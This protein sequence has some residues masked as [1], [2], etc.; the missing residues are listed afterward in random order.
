MLKENCYITHL[1]L[2]NNGIGATGAVMLLDILAS[3]TT[4][5]YLNL[6]GKGRENCDLCM[7]KKNNLYLLLLYF[8]Y[9]KV[10]HLMIK[11][12]NLFLKLLK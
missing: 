2:S 8:Y 4:V 6:S 9:F 1:D 5:T 11:L 7:Y 10:V 3:N 12:L